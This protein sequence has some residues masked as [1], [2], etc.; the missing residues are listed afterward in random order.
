[1]TAAAEAIAAALAGLELESGRTESGF[2]VTLPGTRKL[3]TEVA[4][5]VGR[6]SMQARAF[7]ARRPDENLAGTYGWLL[8]R[9]LRLRGIAFATDR[10]GD[11]HLIGSLPLAM[12]TPEAVDALLG[13]LAETAD[14]SFNTILELGFAESIRKEWRWRL[15][16][17]EPTF[18]LAAFEHLRPKD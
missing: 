17:G 14:D 10:L 15:D 5:V 7:V 3:K 9:N 2:T 4:L 18:N 12:V 13:E 11:I 6:H 1:M 8:Q 16:R